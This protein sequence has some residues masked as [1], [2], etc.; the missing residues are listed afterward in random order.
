MFDSHRSHPTQ[1]TP[2][3]QWSISWTKGRNQK[4]LHNTTRTPQQPQTKLSGESNSNVQ[5]PLQGNIS[6]IRWQL[7]N[8]TVGQITSANSTRVESTMTIKRCTHCFGIP[9]RPWKLWLQQNAPSPTRMCSPIV[10]KQHQ[11]RNLGRTLNRWVVSRNI[12][13]TLPMPQN[14][15]QEN[16]SRKN[17]R[18]SIFQAQIYHATYL[19]AGRHNH[20]STWWFNTCL[21]RKEK[22]ERQHTNW[23]IR[24][25][26]QTTHQH[27][28][29]GGDQ[30]RITRYLWWKQSTP[31][32]NQCHP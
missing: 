15:C 14:L 13:W 12:K 7:P 6:W 26:Q 17:I 31:T 32:G 9:I 30:K 22:H 2:S 24:T 25:N 4:E 10:Q 1:N 16:K 21:E 27:P 23:S 3:G 11:T 18:H 8:A 5:K 19:K 20:K 28:K 29:K